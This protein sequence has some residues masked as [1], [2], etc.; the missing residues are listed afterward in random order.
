MHRL[1]IRIDYHII[2]KCLQF[3]FIYENVNLIFLSPFNNN[4]VSNN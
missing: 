4:K 2:I 1:N 3:V